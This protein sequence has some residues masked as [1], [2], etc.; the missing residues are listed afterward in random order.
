MASWGLASGSL[1]RHEIYMEHEQKQI[2][3][4]FGLAFVFADLIV[5]EEGEMITKN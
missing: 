2:H 5:V 1:E 4:I 3:K